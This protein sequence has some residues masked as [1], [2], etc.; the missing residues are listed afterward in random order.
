MEIKCK[1]HPDK[2]SFNFCHNCGKYFCKDC[3]N[4]GME[5]YYCNEP[6][7]YEKY[8]E[9][10]KNIPVKKVK[11]FASF[12]YRFVAYLID[13]II[14]FIANSIIFIPLYLAGAQIN[15]NDV[16]MDFDWFIVFRHPIFYFTGFLY[17]SIMESSQKMGTFGKRM[18]GIIVVTR[19]GKRI[20]FGRAFARNFCRFFTTISIIGYLLP[21]VLKKKQALHDLLCG[22]LVLNATALPNDLN[23]RVFSC[24]QCN[25]ELELNL[26]EFIK[27]E[28]LCPVCN[29]LNKISS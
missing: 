23:D 12:S 28:F 6:V 13:G 22:T 9:E 21:L 16:V 18:Q 24:E 20:S 25:N 17:F 3:L 5:Y 11:T 1:N 15:P 29:T 10:I 14:L 8:K 19:K 7:C 4:E 26:D 27:K 2:K